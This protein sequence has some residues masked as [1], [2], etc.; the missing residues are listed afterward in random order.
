MEAKTE[1]K[2][3]ITLSGDECTDFISAIKKVVDSDSIPG[4]IKHNFSE[5]EMKVLKE[6]KDGI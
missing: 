2:L 3:T 4:F 1:K 6:I 5:A